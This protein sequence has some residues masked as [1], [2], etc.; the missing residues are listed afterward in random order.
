MGGGRGDKRTQDIDSEDDMG[1][2][3][4]RGGGGGGA[5]SVELGDDVRLERAA[6]LHEQRSLAQ[7]LEVLVRLPREQEL[8]AFQVQLYILVHMHTQ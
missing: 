8:R 7:V 6:D 2:E 3:V 1:Q 4:E 5:D